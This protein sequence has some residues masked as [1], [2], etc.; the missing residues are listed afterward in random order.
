MDNNLGY[1]RDSCNSGL[2][3]VEVANSRPFASPGTS[4]VITFTPAT[5]APR[6]L[7]SH[8]PTVG[9]QQN[10]QPSGELPNSGLSAGFF[11][12]GSSEA[13]VHQIQDAPTGLTDAEWDYGA[14]SNNFSYERVVGRQIDSSPPRGVKVLP[15]GQVDGRQ[16]FFTVDS[17]KDEVLAVQGTPTSVT[18]GEWDYGTSSVYFSN[19]RVVGWW[20]HS[21][22]PLRVE[23]FFT[24]NVEGSHGFFTVGSTKDEVL[25]IQ[26]EPTTLTDTSWGYGLSSV[27]FRNGRVVSWQIWSRDPLKAWISEP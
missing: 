27:Y 8:P 22:D 25:A 15:T 4:Q 3:R 7:I 10:T 6:G 18:D 16:G 23:M 20:I 26:G 19:E 13:V 14:S 12:I 1:V 21:S 2:T 5:E 11:A 17:T 24:E 9:N